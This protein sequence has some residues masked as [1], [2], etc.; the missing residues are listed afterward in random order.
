MS[1]FDYTKSKQY[2][3]SIRLSADGFSFYIHHP[4]IKDENHH[5]SYEVNTSYSMT[6]NIKEMIASTDILKLS[7][8]KVNILIDTPRFTFVPFDL[9][10]DEHTETIFYHNFKKINNETILCNILGKSNTVLLFGVDKY[11]HQLISETFPKARLFACTSPL[12]EFFSTKS[13]EASNRQLYAFL[14]KDILEIHAFDRGKLLLT[15]VFSCKQTSDQVYYLLYVWQQLGYSQT[16]DQLWLI[17]HTNKEK[18]ELLTE[19]RK[20]L[21]Q[22]ETLPN[23]VPNL[24]FDIQTLLICE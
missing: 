12:I 5:V 14:K 17:N 2:T 6:A 18:E 23:I 22:V 21:R 19:L 16:K 1:Q 13:Q 3:L 20:F 9:Y 10:E 7:Y 15:N 4:S 24:P 8:N 11:A